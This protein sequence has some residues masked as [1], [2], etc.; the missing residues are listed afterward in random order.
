MCLPEFSAARFLAAICP[1]TLARGLICSA[2]SCSFSI[3]PGGAVLALLMT[4]ASA[5]LQ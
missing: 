4:M 1:L 3:E 5:I 2:A